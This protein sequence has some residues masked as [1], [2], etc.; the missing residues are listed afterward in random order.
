MKFL[1][2]IIRTAVS[3][4]LVFNI[5]VFG[6]IA[7]PTGMTAREVANSG[8]VTVS[9]AVKDAITPGEIYEVD[10]LRPTVQAIIRLDTQLYSQNV[11]H[12][13]NITHPWKAYVITGDLARKIMLEM[14]ALAFT[15]FMNGRII[16]LAVPGVNPAQIIAHE[17]THVLQAEDSLRIV[18]IPRISSEYEAEVISRIVT[19]FLDGLSLPSYPIHKISKFEK[20]QVRKY[21][22]ITGL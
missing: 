15:D 2:K 8:I 22:A 9:A 3:L 5:G 20:L 14:H 1:K 6:Y 18:K 21:L 10:L 11:G 13:V 16:F 17:F 7:A 4:I 19:S 12:L